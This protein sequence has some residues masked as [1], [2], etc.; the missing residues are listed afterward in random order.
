[1]ALI[2]DRPKKRSDRPTAEPFDR[3]ASEYDRW[4]EDSAVFRAELACLRN[5]TSKMPHPRLEVGVGPGRFAEALGLS[6]GVDPACG[7]LRLATKRGIMVCQAVGEAL[8]FGAGRFGTVV[9]L[10]ALCF[11][12]DRSKVLLE[13]HRVSNK[14]GLLVVGMVPAAGPWG[15]SILAKKQAGNAFYR[16]VDL[17][18]AEGAASLM[19]TAG[20][21]VVEERC[22]LLL[23]PHVFGGEPDNRPGIAA[24]AGF[25]VLV[26]RKK[27]V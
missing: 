3:L 8:P 2:H 15:T 22:G 20:Y 23:P 10:F 24:D 4:F 1:M 21:T 13:A 14:G 6:F 5:L 16:N 9:L 11:V 18:E 17:L 19:R 27:G 26:G 25:V 12:A 7:A